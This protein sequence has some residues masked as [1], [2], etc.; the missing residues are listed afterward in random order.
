M[1]LIIC[2]SCWTGLLVGL[3]L[4]LFVVLYNRI[5]NLH[6]PAGM[7]TVPATLVVVGG[8][9]LAFQVLLLGG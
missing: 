6:I 3:G 7:R 2:C 9:M 1:W 8:I 4:S 5:D